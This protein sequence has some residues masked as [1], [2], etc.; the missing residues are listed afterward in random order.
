[1]LFMSMLSSII[2]I[3]SPLPM[4][5]KDPQP[6]NPW[7]RRCEMASRPKRT[8]LCVLCSRN[9]GP[10][11]AGEKPTIVRLKAKRP[12]RTKSSILAP[13]ALTLQ[14]CLRSSTRQ[15]HLAPCLG[16][17]NPSKT[18]HGQQLKWPLHPKRRVSGTHLPQTN[19]VL[20]A[21]GNKRDGVL[22]PMRLPLLPIRSLPSLPDMD[23][24]LTWRSTSRGPPT[25]Q[26]VQANRQTGV[27]EN[28]ALLSL[29]HGH[30]LPALTPANYEEDL[31]ATGQY[32]TGR[33]QPFPSTPTRKKH[34]QSA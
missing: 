27:G 21:W 2:C 15:P 17:H 24:L 16:A 34:P 18:I 5:K 22:P 4:L 12:R 33:S 9:G 25:L 3:T 23:S 29:A 32:K 28:T 6:K 31:Q 20:R 14:V 19:Q 8:L 13:A 26:R 11:V 7:P 30:L 1:M 10:N